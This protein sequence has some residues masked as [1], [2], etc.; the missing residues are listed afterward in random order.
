MPPPLERERLAI[1]PTVQGQAAGDPVVGS[2]GGKK[3][4]LCG[5]NLS[6]LHEHLGPEGA[7][8]HVTS[9]VNQVLPVARWFAKNIGST[10]AL[11][12]VRSKTSPSALFAAGIGGSDPLVILDFYTGPTPTPT[13]LRAM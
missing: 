12:H 11:E 10:A 6:H 13:F 8:L 5:L 4:A 7:K 1:A 3:R 2:V 9:K